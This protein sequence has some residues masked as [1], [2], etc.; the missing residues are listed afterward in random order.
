MANM[1]NIKK[2]EEQ[3]PHAMG[4]DAVP[5]K[6]APAPTADVDSDFM[7]AEKRGHNARK[8]RK[9]IWK[10]SRSYWKRLLISACLWLAVSFTFLFFGPIEIT[11]GS[12]DSVPFTIWQITPLM[13]GA[14]AIVFVIGAFLLPLLRGRVFNYTVCVLFAGL[15]G[16]YIQGNFLNGQLGA[17]TGD[18]V[19]WSGQTKKMLLNLLVWTCILLVPFVIHFFS[20]KVWRRV[21]TFLS[22]ALIVMQTTALVSLYTGAAREAGPETKGWFL[23]EDGLYTYS[24]QKNTLLFLLDRL[25]YDYMEQVMATDPDFFDRLDGFTS[26][27]NAISE[28]ARTMP[29]ANYMLTG[30]EEAFM[31]PKKEFFTKSWENEGHNA[32]RAMHEAGYEVSVFSDIKNIFGDGAA[33]KEYVSNI[34]TANDKMNKPMLYKN[35]LTLSAYRYTPLAMKPFFWCYTDEVANSAFIESKRYE[36]DEAKYAAGF[37][38][39]TSLT[40]AAGCFKFYHFMGPHAPYSLQEDGTR[41]AGGTS[42]VAQTKGSFQILFD[43]FDRMK[44]LGIYEDTAIV[45]TA[46]HGDPVYDTEPVQKATR[47]GL[48]YKPPGAADE[49][50]VWSEAPVSL[51]NIP[52]TLLKSMNLDYEA[53]GRPLDEIGEREEITRTFYKSVVHDGKEKELYIYEINGHA[54]DFNHWVI[55]EKKE[56]KYPFY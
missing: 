20:R 10:D 52:A 23:S 44:E 54:A 15:A 45:I 41:S 47:I 18:A 43:L 42:L 32:L 24:S 38:E 4:V 50:L 31:I 21:V 12:S 5:S 16:G 34:T 37:R 6:T 48:F 2:D 3:T 36:I 29:A 40:K 13:A 33:A 9:S 55:K 51:K 35:L 30:S 26:Y 19:D 22:A 7:T 49:P 56:I 1:L 14:A 17:L 46:D 11:A 8:K 28:H 27:T 53:Y 39:T 25:D